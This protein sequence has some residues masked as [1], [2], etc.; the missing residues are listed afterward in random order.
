MSVLRAD[1]P[2]G[3]RVNGAMAGTPDKV[4]A[5]PLTT[6]ELVLPAE[7][8]REFFLLFQQGVMVPA[9]AGCTL[10]QLLVEQWG[11]D[12][13]YVTRRIT[14]I[15]LDGRPVDDVKTALVRV[16]AVLALSGAM[17]GLVGAT[18]RRGGF[19]AAMRG[20]ISYQES[21]ASGSDQVTPVRLKLFNLLLPELVPGFLLRG[22]VL[23]DSQLA[24]LLE[25]VSEAF[26][27]GI[28]A[29]RCNGVTLD[30]AQLRHGGCRTGNILLTV[31][32]EDGEP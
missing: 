21:M 27:E 6:L 5:S 7:R 10:E 3:N 30:P 28:A 1:P 22:I 15:F 11:V 31:L 26:W 16:G 19:Y 4:S 8:A 12:S 13:D 32:F 20:G 2:A 17:P 24:E 9:R 23:T 29:C 25:G 14:T 18:M